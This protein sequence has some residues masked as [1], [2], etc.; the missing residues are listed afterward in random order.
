VFHFQSQALE[1]LTLLMYTVSVSDVK[2][3]K[4]MLKLFF[5]LLFIGHF[6]ILTA[7]DQS[8]MI[9][10]IKA[11]HNIPDIITIMV[12]PGN[13]K[14]QNRDF[15]N[16]PI[17][18]Q[19]TRPLLFLYDS[20][21]K[22]LFKTAFHYPIAKTI[23]PRPA[24]S[25]DQNS[26]DVIPIK[27]PEVFLLVPFFKAVKFIEIYNPGES[28][29]T[30][31]KEFDKIDVHYE[32]DNDSFFSI[33]K[34]CS[35]E[36]KKL[37]ILIIASGYSVSDMSIFSSK[38]AELKTYLLSCEPF[39]S[40]ASL[41]DIHIYENLA[42]LGC[43]TGC[44][45]ID[46]LM[47]CNSGKVISTAV[48]SGYLFDEII[49]IHNT[50]TYSGGGYREYLDAYKTN[51]YNTYAMVYNGNR[52][53]EMALHEFGHSFGNLCDEYTYGSEGYS[54]NLCVNCRE[55]CSDWS[56]ISAACQSSCDARSDYFRPK[57]SI[58]LSLS[59]PYY[60]AVSIYSTYSPDGLEKRL[61]FFTSQ[62][63]WVY[64]TIDAERK[65]ERAWIIRKHYG[66]IDI[67]VDN[68]DA[69]PVSKFVVYRKEGMDYQVVKEILPS[70]L[71]L[72]NGNFSFTFTDEYLEKNVT[73]T[74]KVE[75]LDLD[76]RVIGISN[77]KTI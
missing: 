43:Y 29:P 5:I 59:I 34:P 61:Q 76:G 39:L 37:H 4:N 14:N 46:R 49:V 15:Q 73:Y 64:I 8:I 65:E 74:Y 27:E 38:A 13:L 1:I 31:N 51:S 70:E 57:N 32:T 16:G 45:G 12:K 68:P 58:M 17:P 36:E 75:A 26:P 66:K 28:I 9:I 20:S 44:S 18:G 33:P 48:S 55:N 72:Q 54:Y 11:K 40:Y 35:G 52:Y 42:D 71:E 3:K 7:E 25:D 67:T 21:G 2:M 30:C 63:I 10:G 62:D 60:N 22:I 50:N 41:V 77:E 23:P 24:D 56:S 47:C 69:V 19:N 6:C 53:K